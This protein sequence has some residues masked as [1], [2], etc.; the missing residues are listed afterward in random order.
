MKEI[1]LNPLQEGSNYVNIDKKNGRIFFS[2]AEGGKN[3]NRHTEDG[4]NTLNSLK[5]ELNVDEV[6]YI[7]QIHS[8]R[9]VVYDKNPADF[10]EEEGDAIITDKKNVAIGVFT[11]D[12]VPVILLDSKK[13][14]CAA[15]HSGWKGTIN[16]I[17][18]KTIRRMQEVYG[19]NIGDIEAF[20][21]PHIRQCCYEVSEELKDEFIDRMDVDK[22]ILFKGRNLSLEECILSTLRNVGVN[23]CN[24]NSLK[25]C[26]YCSDK[27]KLHSYR[28][29]DGNY[30]RMFSF[31]I[32]K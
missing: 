11:A 3:F 15:I 31:I 18:E 21:G 16:K 6:I 9:V 2:T 26:T 19:C 12:C 22:E 28:K 24:I 1:K 20:I 25:L 30:G 5:D 27:I 10:I 32:L 17:T 13:D 23:E 29:S 8:D 14:V 4:V 7:R